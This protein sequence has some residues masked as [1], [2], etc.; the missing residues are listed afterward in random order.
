MHQTSIL[1]VEDEAIIRMMLVEMLEELGHRVIAEAGNVQDGR[2][3]AEIE[4]FD[5]A[6]LDI[7]L[8]G[9][10]VQPV[11]EAVAARGLPSCSSAVM[12]RRASQSPFGQTRFS[13][14]RVN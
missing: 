14:N 13:P 12:D 6:I 4:E 7:N 10:D 8:D 2:S 3:L 11:A 1:L 5:L 9:Q